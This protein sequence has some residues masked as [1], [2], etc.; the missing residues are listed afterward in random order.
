MA[1]TR[2]RSASVV[3]DQV[4]SRTSSIL[5][6]FTTGQKT[7]TVLAAA[8]LVLGALFFVRW[9]STPSMAPLFTDLAAAD[10]A[11]ITDEL[12][13]AGIPYELADGG[14]TI[15]V[16]RERVYETRLDM[17]AQGM[18]G[19]SSDGYALLD[20]QGITTS[21]FRQRVDYQRAM[22]GELAATISSIEAVQQAS[23]HLVIPEDDLF[24]DD[25]TRAT[26]SVLVQTRPGQTIAPGQVQAIVNLVAASVEG[27]DPSD[28]AVADQTGRVLAAP[29]E[30]GRHMAAGDARAAQTA[31][32]ED[33][34]ASSLEEMLGAVVGDGNA[35]VQV[36]AQL[37]FDARETTSE[38]FGG[39][40][41]RTGIPLSQQQTTETYTGTGAEQVGVLGPEGQP[42]NGAGDQTDYQLNDV[43]TQFAVDR[44]VTQVS[45]APGA[46]QRLSV[47]VLLDDGAPN[48]PN[49]AEVRSLV[50]AAVGFNP[51]R[52]DLS[53]PCFPLAARLGTA[54]QH[55]AL[56][57]AGWIAALALP[58]A[59]AELEAM[60]EQESREQMM[61]LART[62]GA[63][64]IVLIVLLLA[65]RSAKRAMPPRTVPIDL[66]T[67]ELDD[68]LDEDEEERPA[69]TAPRP[70]TVQDEVA[71]LIDSQPDD[72]AQLLRGWLAERG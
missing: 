48:Q 50:E 63:I 17:S 37:D 30:E 35:V 70:P 53:L 68:D 28:V 12:D 57:L 38:T 1:T 34:L 36:N 52:G 23:V 69:L 66:T 7:M 51:E 43:A 42:I 33:R 45:T 60:A 4:R 27:L 54:G 15:L 24:S 71:Q 40:G 32:F 29:G 21:E 46:V 72:V 20:Q 13:S 31:A 44:V 2:Q 64:L 10:A 25:A 61:A 67:L 39:D 65:W 8:A 59:A 55:A 22:E 11:A 3:V 26:A 9:I 58:D 16:P 14:R 19:S 41:P 18:P 62:G 56:A 49:P 6:G 5:G 47:A